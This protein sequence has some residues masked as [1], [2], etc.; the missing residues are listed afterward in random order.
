MKIAAVTQDQLILIAGVPAQ[1]REL[2]GY[3]MTRGE[4]AVHFDTDLG[5]GHIEYLDNRNNVTLSQEDFDK[6][7]A[8]LITEHKRYLDHVAEQQRSAEEAAAN[9]PDTTTEPG[10]DSGSV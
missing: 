8:W 6:H 2:G 9:E 1:M 4:W 5:Y 10:S 7:Y 3:H